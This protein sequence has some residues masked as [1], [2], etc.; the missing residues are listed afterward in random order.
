MVVLHRLLR[1]LRYLL[2]LFQD[3]LE[4]QAFEW[5]WSYRRMRHRILWARSNPRRLPRL[6]AA[7]APSATR[8]AL[9]RL[10]LANWFRLLAIYFWGVSRN[11]T[12]QLSYVWALCGLF[13]PRLTTPL[14]RIIFDQLGGWLG[15]FAGLALTTL[16]VACFAMAIVLS[17]RVLRDQKHLLGSL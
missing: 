16:P 9:H 14:G 8:S 12:Y 15:L 11:R 3:W 13:L 7:H 4:Q 5:R 17:V 2:Y 1:T 6:L 10:R